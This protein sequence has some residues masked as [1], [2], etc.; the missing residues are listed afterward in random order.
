MGKFGWTVD[1]AVVEAADEAGA[2]SLL[3]D[4]DAQAHGLAVFRVCPEGHDGSFRALLVRNAVGWIV[5][6]QT[7]RFAVS[8]AA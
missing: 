7:L 2:A 5:P 4:H 1:D 6:E 8:D 3:A